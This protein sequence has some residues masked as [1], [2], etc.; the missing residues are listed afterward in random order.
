MVN[1]CSSG[2][3]VSIESRSQLNLV[4]LPPFDYGLQSIKGSRC[5]KRSDLIV[6]M[7]RLR[8]RIYLE[9]GAI[10]GNAVRDGRHRTPQDARSWHLLM[11]DSDGEVRGC[12]RAQVHNPAASLSKLAAYRAARTMDDPWGHRCKNALRAEM[13]LAHRLGIPVIE[14]GGLAVDQTIRGSSAL[15]KMTGGLQNLAEH[16]GGAIAIGT[17][18]CRHNTSL[19]LRRI[20]GQSLQDGGNTLPSYYDPRYRCEME[21]LKFYSWLPNHHQRRYRRFSEHLMG[22]F[23]HHHA[24]PYFVYKKFG[25]T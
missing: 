23:V 5:Q 14:V 7:Q 16:L 2:E 13:S 20:G 3:R 9:D 19:V 18:T 6:R 4:V 10:E 15:V 1:L 11:E 21:I 25:G 12:I 17:V 8:G 24:S 22:S